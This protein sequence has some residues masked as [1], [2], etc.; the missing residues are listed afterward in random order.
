MVSN[1]ERKYYDRFLQNN[2]LNQRYRI[3]LSDGKTLV[4]VPKAY[5]KVDLGNPT[6]FI[7]GS[8]FSLRDVVDAEEMSEIIIYATK[9]LDGYTCGLE[10]RS[11]AAIKAQLPSEPNPVT[12]VFISY[13]PNSDI[14]F[15]YDA[16]WKHIAELLTGLSAEKLQ[17]FGKVVFV[18]PRTL[19]TLFEPSAQHV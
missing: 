6:F 2:L 11:K 7:N 5:S 16:I 9:Q 19:K 13:G 14:E 4:G 18:D 1:N 8:E 3:K 10:P 15:Q 12:S 17:E